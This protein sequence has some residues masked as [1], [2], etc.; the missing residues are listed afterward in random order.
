MGGKKDPP[1]LKGASDNQSITEH[2]EWDKKD[3][4][5]TEATP[6]LKTPFEKR[7]GISS[8][9]MKKLFDSDIIPDGSTKIGKLRNRINALIKD[10][11][12]ANFRDY[13]M[14][15][16][17]D[18]A[19]NVSSQQ[20]T[21]T[22]VRSVM[23]KYGGGS[24]EEASAAVKAWGLSEQEMFDDVEKTDAAGGKVTVK[25]LNKEVFFRIFVPIVKAYVTVRV[26]KLFNDRNQYPFLKF[27]PIHF[28]EQNR[29]RCE[30]VT[31][32]VQQISQLYGYPATLR[33]AILQA[34]LYSFCFVFP[35]EAWNY[36]EQVG[37]DGK[38]H[39]VREGLCYELPH[40][41]R[42]FYD[43]NKRVTQFNTDSGGDYAGYWRILKFG[44]IQR[45]PLYW[46]K[47]KISYGTNWFDV[48]ISGNFFAEVYP[49]LSKL[50]DNVTMP[51]N[52]SDTQ[53]RERMQTF[54]TTSENERP[55]FVTDLFIRLKPA[56][57]G[58]SKYKYNVWFRFVVASDCDL[59]WAEPVPYN[60]VLFCGYDVND[61]TFRWP[62]LALEII[63]WQDHLSNVFTN[64]LAATKQNLARFVAYDTDQ[65][66]KGTIKDLRTSRQDVSQ[67]QF[68]GYSGKLARVKQQ[69]PGQMFKPVTFQPQ[70]VQELNSVV[71][72]ILLALERM[73]GMSTQEL[74]SAGP[75]VQTAEE[76]RV[77]SGSSS[78]R[79]DYTGSFVDDFLD[80]WK[81]QLWTACRTYGDE[82]FIAN[83][84]G[85]DEEAITGLVQ[86]GFII[87]GRSKGI[88]TVQGK[89]SLLGYQALVS[90]REALSR[91]NQPAI[92]Q[93]MMQALQQVGPMIIQAGGLVG[94]EHV[95][96]LFDRAAQLAGVPSDF[97]FKVPPIPPPQPPNPLAKLVE[98]IN[99]K[100]LDSKTKMQWL[101]LMGFKPDDQA[102]QLMMAKDLK[103][104]S[105]AQVKEMQ[106]KMA[107][108][109]VPLANEVQAQQNEEHNMKMQLANL[110]SVMTLL[111]EKIDKMTGGVR[112]TAPIA[113]DTVGR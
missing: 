92:A 33:Q 95:V 81:R 6:D 11:R 72:T 59:I 27:E 21:A 75:H 46:N 73:L 39:T 42:T 58:L 78:T 82:D 19:Y 10:G 71:N 14:Y 103:Q 29:M 111:N 76:N 66:D 40:P 80:A 94:L 15:A 96:A 57:W 91:I 23:Q 112:P 69:D 63:P 47:G 113:L 64:I 28:N 87:Q 52:A 22:L 25:V 65:V 53:S 18:L 30:M 26:A 74:G 84:S 16:A 98:N 109:V 38:V 32:L 104:A 67:V 56:E 107:E 31:D 105:P 61:V 17:I 35:S 4:L 101:A 3:Q 79:I 83:T 60:P 41:T 43:S 36:E 7:I 70:N 97:R 2:F 34:A 1:Q 8:A 55:C 88:L 62:S 37:E 5:S 90:T 102:F 48:G 44:D 45:N 77:L 108:Q 99:F 24:Y 100:D 89:W 49:C 106:E 12:M 51:W 86:M 110:V 50:Y 68:F 93:V 9:A 85:Y 13:K 54:Y 20:T